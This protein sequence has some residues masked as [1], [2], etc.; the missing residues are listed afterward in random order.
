M[1]IYFNAPADK[2]CVHFCFAYSSC[3]FDFVTFSSSPTKVLGCLQS[4]TS[5]V[6]EFHMTRTASKWVL[7]LIRNEHHLDS[8]RV[9][10]NL[11][12]V[13][14][15]TLL[16]ARLR[17]WATLNQFTVTFTPRTSALRC[18]SAVVNS[19]WLGVAGLQMLCKQKLCIK[20]RKITTNQILCAH[21]DAPH[22]YI[23]D[24]I[25]CIKKHGLRLGKFRPL[26]HNKNRNQLNW[27][28]AN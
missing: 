22:A 7:A 15:C 17:S 12:Y 5:D 4:C 23:R 20:E 14:K 28:F 24:D 11:A 8:F 2:R 13:T 3:R 25:V 27:A 9:Q 16:G 21:F 19:L 6:S 10:V 1:P 18:S 26:T